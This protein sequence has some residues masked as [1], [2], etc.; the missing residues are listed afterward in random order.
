[1]E[2][3]EKALRRRFPFFGKRSDP[4]HQ[5]LEEAIAE[6]NQRIYQKARSDPRYY[7]MGTTLAAMVFHGRHATI[8]HIGDSR[9]YR[10]RHGNLQQ[11]TRDHT[12]VQ[13]QVDSGWMSEQEAEV[14]VYK[15]L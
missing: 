10:C 2:K 5:H 3:L 14:S 7:G 8:A 13:G 9:I 12:W 6:V 11:L 1:R 15:S 4:V